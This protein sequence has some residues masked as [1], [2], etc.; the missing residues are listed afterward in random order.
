MYRLRAWGGDGG[1]GDRETRHT[2]P[3][4]LSLVSMS[5]EDFS[6]PGS[7]L[8]PLLPPPLAPAPGPAPPAP[9]RLRLRRSASCHQFDA[10]GALLQ[11][12]AGLGACFP[13]EL[14][15][16]LGRPQLPKFTD[17]EVFLA[18]HPGADYTA[19]KRK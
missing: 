6:S 7:S 5:G 14:G 17:E 16:G 13:M 15:P 8:A 2:P 10:R 19:S 9:P 11:W 3:S 4:L 12:G 1:G 18:N